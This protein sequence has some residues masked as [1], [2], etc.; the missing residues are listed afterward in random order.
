MLFK[1]SAILLTLGASAVNG[2]YSNNTIAQ[3]VSTYEKTNAAVTTTIAPNYS[4]EPVENVATYADDITTFYVTN[5]VYSTHWLTNSHSSST[6]V[7]NATYP[8]TTASPS[9]HLTSVKNQVTTLTQNN[10]YYGNVSALQIDTTTSTS[11]STLLTTVTKGTSNRTLACVPKTQYVTVTASA[12]VQ[13]VTVTE[14]AKTSFVTV[15]AQPLS[16]AFWS[17]NTNTN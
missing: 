10:P 12:K 2:L 7:K 17:N 15:T 16:Q 11:T 1:N 14:E 4:V 3:P 13:Y 6:E 9:S 8:V 5:T